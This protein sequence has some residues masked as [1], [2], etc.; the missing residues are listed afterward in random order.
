MRKCQLI[1]DLVGDDTERYF[2]IKVNGTITQ[3]DMFLMLLAVSNFIYKT[4]TDKGD[5]KIKTV[6]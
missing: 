5:I 6:D 4:L 1:V 3:Q 2:K